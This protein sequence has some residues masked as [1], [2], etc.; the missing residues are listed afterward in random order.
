M[1]S[2]NVLCS[3]AL[4]LTCTP[5]F[6]V[7]SAAS[8]WN[9]FAK[10]VPLSLV[11]QVTVP[12]GDSPPAPPELL[13]P[14]DSLLSPPQPASSPGAPTTAAAPSA[15]LR[16]ERRLTPSAAADGGTKRA[17]YSVSDS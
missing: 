9:C 7:K 14:G 17:R 16:M 2:W 5:L 6:L 15:V 1:F 4:I 8:A 11:P 3:T 10:V 12:V 13:V